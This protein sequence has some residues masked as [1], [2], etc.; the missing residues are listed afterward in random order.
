MFVLAFLGVKSSFPRQHAKLCF[1]VC[2]THLTTAKLLA[3]DFFPER[4]ESSNFENNVLFSEC[5]ARTLKYKIQV[6]LYQESNLRPSD[7]QLGRSTT[8]LQAIKLGSWD[9]HPGIC[10]ME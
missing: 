9:K 3:A 2:P 4:A 7:Y 6:L 5:H 1:V 10:A 8:E